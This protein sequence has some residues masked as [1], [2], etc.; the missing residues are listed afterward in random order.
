M[1]HAATTVDLLDGSNPP[2]RPDGIPLVVRLIYTA[3]AAVT[4][5]YYWRTYGPGNFLFFC[6]IALLLTLV[7][8]WLESSLLIS[9]QAVAILLPQ[10]IWVVD[11]ADH[12]AGV[13]M[14][15]VTD[16]MFNPQYPPFVRGLS[17]YH[18]W[19]P[20]LLLWLLSRIGY[21]RRAFA[22]QVIFGIAVLLICY[23][24]FVP[25][26]S[27]ATGWR[28]VN[29]NYVFGMDENNPQTVMPPLA[30]LAMLLAVVPVALY[31]PTHLFL[32]QVFR[33]PSPAVARGGDATAD[34]RADRNA[35][36]S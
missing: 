12:L 20:F 14:L 34:M 11:F 13:K 6:D 10:M 9:M 31:L 28:A 27:G 22:A 2:K 19:L 1:N 29:I 36:G 7:G 15:G 33:G 17:L 8:M 32:K 23:F 3:F 30:W 25:P 4:V 18:G 26:S 24:A 21:D 16:Y 5:P 35:D